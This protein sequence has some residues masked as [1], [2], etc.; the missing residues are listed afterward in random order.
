MRGQKTTIVSSLHCSVW[1]PYII[2]VI[3]YAS[4]FLGKE[5]TKYPFFV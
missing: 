2:Y 5:T 1:Q 3:M 4:I